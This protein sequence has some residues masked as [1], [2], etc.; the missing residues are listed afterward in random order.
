MV[1]EA[2]QDDIRVSQWDIDEEAVFPSATDADAARD[3]GN[4]SDD[5]S[6]ISSE[7]DFDED[8]IKM[9]GEGRRFVDTK[10]TDWTM[11]NFDQMPK[12]TFDHARSEIWENGKKEIKFFQK[13][14]AEQF[15]AG[16]D[17]SHAETV[18]I[19]FWWV[20]I[21]FFLELTS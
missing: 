15:D 5:V 7:E 16:C 20:L 2:D 3:Q 14:I 6:S 18:A 4:E 13:K 12:V 9:L 19:D 1:E 10:A 11:I 17:G 21:A 8:D